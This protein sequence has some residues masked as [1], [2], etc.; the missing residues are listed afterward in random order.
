MLGIG[1]LDKMVI[2]V[3]IFVAV[4]NDDLVR[5]FCHIARV[6]FIEWWL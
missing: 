6:F 3:L 1:G 2:V 5:G 4:R